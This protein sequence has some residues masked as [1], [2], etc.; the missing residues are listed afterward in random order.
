VGNP[1]CAP[2]KNHAPSCNCHGSPI[3]GARDHSHTLRE[4]DCLASNRHKNRAHNTYSGNDIFLGRRA[5]GRRFY[6]NGCL[7]RRKIY[8]MLSA[9]SAAEEGNG[10]GDECYPTKYQP[11]SN[12]ICHSACIIQ[13]KFSGIQGLGRSARHF[14]S[15]PMRPPPLCAPLAGAMKKAGYV[16]ESFKSDS[17]ERTYRI[18]QYA[19]R[20][21]PRN[22]AASSDDL[23]FHIRAV[24]EGRLV[25]LALSGR[26]STPRRRSLARASGSF[27]LPMRAIR[28]TRSRK[29]SGSPA[30]WNSLPSP[31]PA[32]S[33]AT[34]PA[35][36]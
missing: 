4:L 21:S 11:D 17:G 5:C 36:R 19:G 9:P 28:A 14:F 34:A 15:S 24:Y 35:G 23:R 2:R 10:R 25:S 31:A 32:G 18:H 13:L 29:S 26:I 22:L 7:L 27:R 8:A 30:W 20:L 33:T 16:V 3:S 1:C 6:L 12:R